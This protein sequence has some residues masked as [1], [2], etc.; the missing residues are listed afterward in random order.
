MFGSKAIIA[1]N[2]VEAEPVAQVKGYCPAFARRAGSKTA[3]V[4][5]EHGNA[6]V[7]GLFDHFARYA[8]ELR[9]LDR[10]TPWRARRTARGVIFSFGIN[11]AVCR[12]PFEYCVK[13]MQKQ[14]CHISPLIIAVRYR[15]ADFARL[16]CGQPI[17]F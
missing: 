10:N 3:A 11:V 13:N 12:H 14:A 17:L 1:R 2:T 6:G 9:P 5:I 7:S 15:T 4:N 8:A 16:P